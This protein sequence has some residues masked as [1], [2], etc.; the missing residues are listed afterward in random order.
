M[1][2]SPG[3]VTAQ[4]AASVWTVY[5]CQTHTVTRRVRG[6][7]GGPANSSQEEAG[8]PGQSDAAKLT[9]LPTHLTSEHSFCELL[10]VFT[11]VLF[12]G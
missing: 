2:Q 9:V 3:H 7:T 5:C 10:V 11:T 4:V 8:R 12:A 6:A 1:T